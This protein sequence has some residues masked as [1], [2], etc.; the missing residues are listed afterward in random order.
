MIEPVVEILVLL[1]LVAAVVVIV[2]ALAAVGVGCVLVLR[3]LLRTN[4]V[5]GWF[6]LPKGEK[7]QG[8]A[9]RS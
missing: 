1:L 8:R 2:I 5:V 7:R 9:R 3:V 6:K 4:N